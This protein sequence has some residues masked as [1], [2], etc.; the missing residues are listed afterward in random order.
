[1][2][3]S[4]AFRSGAFGSGAFAAPGLAWEAFGSV[5]FA[6]ARAAGAFEDLPA[7]L[8]AAG[9]FGSVAKDSALPSRVGTADQTIFRDHNAV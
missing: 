2:R 9:F 1:M 4:T 5:A 8:P 6:L 7:A 3:P